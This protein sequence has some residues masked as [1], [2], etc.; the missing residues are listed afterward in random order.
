M[1]HL[2]DRPEGDTVAVGRRASLV[3]VGGLHQPVGVLLKLPDQAAL[4]DAAFADDGHVSR[5]AVAPDRLP[6]VLEQS[7]LVGAASKGGL[8]DVG[9]ALA[10]DLGDDLVDPVG[11]DRDR[12]ALDQVLPGRLEGDGSRGCAHG[13]LADV[14]RP[15]LRNGLQT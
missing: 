6:Q 9:P 12:L 2:L 4:A 11:V 3:P 10:S 7:E 8:Q 5:L 13:G 1:D 14:D 15:G